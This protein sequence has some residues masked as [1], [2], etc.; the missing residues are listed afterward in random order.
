MQKKKAS[1]AVILTANKVEYLAVR[2]YLENLHEE[3][4]PQGTIYERG[5][6]P[7]Q[8]DIWEV[9]IGE[10]GLGG[11]TGALE[12]ERILS[13]YQPEIVLFVG[14][15]GGIKDVKRGDIVVA[16]KV[17]GYEQSKEST[18]VFKPQPT[19]RFATYHMVQ[20]ARIEARKNDWL[21]R[22]QNESSLVS[23]RVHIGPL[24]AGE[25]VSASTSTQ[26]LRFLR[27]TYGDGLAIEMEGY[28][29]FQAL[30]ANEQVN[31]LIGH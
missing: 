5:I 27:K 28:G 13:F 16:P 24:V 19:I 17:Y 21:K 3:V 31:T 23:P 26:L 30:N 25:K 8:R 10:I 1:R 20:R 6:F 2:S 18:D 11:A 4:H 22:L 29:F 12:T 9:V 7:L 14:I 15:A